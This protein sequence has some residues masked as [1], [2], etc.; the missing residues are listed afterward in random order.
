LTITRF[1]VQESMSGLFEIT[2]EA[3]SPDDDLDLGSI[4]GRGAGFRVSTSVKNP[5]VGQRA[6]TG[7]VCAMEL[8]HSEP[9]GASTYG[10]R[11]VPDLWLLTQR[12]NH[13]I[14]QHF[15]IPDIVKKIF[16]EWHIQPTWKIDEGT[17]AKLEM[18]VQYGESDF[19]FVSRL[20]E[21]AGI[22]YWFA[23]EKGKS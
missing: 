19:A 6:W 9:T 17:Y 7:V 8:L 4:V 5:L 20:L 21:E 3:L 22:A 16:G 13:R 12:R 10:L 18:R 23:D 1:S 2:I 15:S 11:L 14:F